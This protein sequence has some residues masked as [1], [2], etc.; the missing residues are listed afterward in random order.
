VIPD[1][2]KSDVD[3]MMFAAN[4]PET[5]KNAAAKPAKGCRPTA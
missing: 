2:R 1:K 4:P 3:K 5:P